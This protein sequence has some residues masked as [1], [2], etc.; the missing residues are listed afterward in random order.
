MDGLS[1][2]TA[3]DH[4]MV[5]DGRAYCLSPLTLADYGRIENQILASRPDPCDAVYQRLAGLGRE[6]QEQELS[7][8]YDLAA[9]ARHVTLDDLDQW[10]R[11]PTG[12]CRRFWL[13]IRK[14]QPHVALEEVAAMLQ[15]LPV[16]RRPELV[17]CMEACHGLPDE[18]ETECAAVADDAADGD[19]AVPWREW[20]R[21]LSRIY[22]W[23]P[24]QIG[25]LTIAQVWL[26]LTESPHA[27][28][29]RRMSPAE[30]Q[31]YCARRQQHR[32]QWIRQMMEKLQ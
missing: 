14:R 17:R 19:I 32:Q 11:T 23:T 18:R 25:Q 8:A 5:I 26:Y 1:Q 7:R 20:A 10:W 4:S 9:A 22:G 28:A 24:G 16:E 6:E 21:R 3:A 29:R 15:R 30:G 27:S 2:L 13:M 12:F 31:A